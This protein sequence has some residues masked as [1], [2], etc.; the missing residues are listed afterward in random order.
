MKNYFK[1]KKSLKNLIGKFKA[2]KKF[3]VVKEHNEIV[4]DFR[5]SPAKS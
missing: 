1:N 4:S 3:D 5:K 2:G